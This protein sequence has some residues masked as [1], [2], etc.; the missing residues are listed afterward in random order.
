MDQFIATY[1]ND[2]G[3]LNG[4]KVVAKAWTDPEYQ[5]GC[6]PTAPPPSPNSA[7][8]GPQGEHIVVVREHRR[9]CTTSSSARCAPATRGRCS[10]CRRPGTRTRPTGRAWCGSRARCC[11][12]WAWTSP[13][14]SAIQVWDCSSRGALPR[15]ARAARRHRGPDRGGARRR[16]SPATRWSA[17]PRWRRRSVPVDLDVDGP[18][19]PPRSNGELVFAEPWESRAFGLAMALNDAGPSTGRTSARAHRPDQA[20]GEDRPARGECWSH[21][22]CWEHAL[23]DV[24]I[25]R[26]RHRDRGE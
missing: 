21:H 18:A 13:T 16:S 23:E 2:V 22:R 3:P 15:A 10:G 9:R 25:A 6:W 1:E 19:A 24:L 14:T 20:V 26:C 17:W 11:P 7:S 4:A 5:A 12:R 8:T